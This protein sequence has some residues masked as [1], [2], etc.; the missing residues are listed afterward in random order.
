M[1]TLIW[2]CEAL[3]PVTPLDCIHSSQ[4][5]LPKPNE[6]RSAFLLKRDSEEQIQEYGKALGSCRQKSKVTG[7]EGH[8]NSSESWASGW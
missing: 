4:G 8:I 7:Y 5:S 2:P 1:L 6:L 3:I